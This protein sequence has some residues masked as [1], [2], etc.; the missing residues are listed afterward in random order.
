MMKSWQ[1]I[2]LLGILVLGVIAG[3]VYGWL[4]DPV[5]YID[6]SI[7]SL[8]ID[9]QTD[10]VLMTAEVYST[11]SD[12]T[13]A[14]QKLSLVRSADIKGLMVNSVEYARQMNFSTQDIEKLILL[15]S[16]VEVY[17]SGDL[18]RP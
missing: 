6:T 5:E 16:A 18:D 12:I 4:I 10:L 1:V 17:V 7:N 8:S 13:T 2:L 11:D 14:I 3:L 15:R 9:Y